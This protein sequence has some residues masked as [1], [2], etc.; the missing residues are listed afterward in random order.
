MQTPSALHPPCQHG[1]GLFAVRERT[2]PITETA[3]PYASE[4]DLQEAVR[5]FRLYLE[6]LQE[7]DRRDKEGTDSR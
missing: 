6:I 7:W 4:L 2:R 3:L 1:Q 5:N